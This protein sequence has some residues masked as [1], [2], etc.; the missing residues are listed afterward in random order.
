MI[1][2]VSPKPGSSPGDRDRMHEDETQEPGS[3]LRRL[4]GW[5]FKVELL[6]LRL[7][8]VVFT[9]ANVSLPSLNR[10]AGPVV[11]ASDWRE[12]GPRFDTRLRRDFSGSSQTSDFKIDTPEASLPGSAL[13]LVG[14]VSVY[15][16]WVR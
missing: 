3:G 10:L 16:D 7:S 14:L 2:P 15:C 9:E 1:P 8:L 5:K 13:G 12:E 11:K 4:N 6:S